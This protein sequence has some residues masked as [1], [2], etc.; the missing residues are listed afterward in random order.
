MENMRVPGGADRLVSRRSLLGLGAA[1]G[2][3]LALTGC[4]RGPGAPALVR[5]DRD[6]LEDVE[7]A[8]LRPG[9]PGY[10]EEAGGFN[11]A[12]LREPALIV[13]AAT[14]EDVARAVRYAAARELPIGVMATGH[15]NSVPL[16]GGVLVTTRALTGVTVRRATRSAR[17]D[18]GVVWSDVVKQSTRLGLAPL[19][20]S[21]GTVGVVGYTVGGGLSPTLGRLHGY[22]A[23]H[24]RRVELVTADGRRRTVS[25]DV[26]EDLF[27]A[28]RGAK[29]NVGIVTAMEFGLFPVRTLYAAGL[30]LDGAAAAETIATWRDWA[31][32]APDDMSSSVA[33]LQLP[34]DP[35][36]PEPLRGKLVVHVRIAYAGPPERGAAL[37]RPLRD[38]GPVLLDTVAELPFA[39]FASIHADPVTPVPAYERTA[40]L[41]ALP[42]AAVDRL[43]ALAGPGSGSPLAVVEV[44]R[45]GGALARRP[46]EDN[47]VSNRH[48]SFNLFAAGVGGPEQAGA[49]KAHAA[50]VV[51]DLAPWSTGGT[52]VNFLSTEESTPEQVRTAYSPQAYARLAAI[53]RSVDPANLFRLNHNIPPA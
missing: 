8:V 53:K 1:A 46:A 7:G 45:L 30:Y 18:A 22:A 25:A 50:R 15:Q 39:D 32:T 31:G 47:A 35:A 2:A 5:P 41:G 10:A 28:V 16:D 14:A 6:S 43:V 48:A 20:G 13:A 51:T 37:V 26:D 27:W 40:Q 4:V 34:P 52:L 17:V 38:S 42:D 3:A 11:T 24:V 29:S 36:V 19:A 21:A 49:I 9:D 44:R 12:L 33:L 23:D